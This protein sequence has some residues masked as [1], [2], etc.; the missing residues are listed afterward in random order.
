MHYNLSSWNAGFFKN[1]TLAS[2]V[3]KFPDF[4]ATECSISCSRNQSTGHH[5]GPIYCSTHRQTLFLY[6]H[7][8][9]TF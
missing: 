6:I 2:L 9:I 8:N 5:P 1:L 4:L 3:N 7:D